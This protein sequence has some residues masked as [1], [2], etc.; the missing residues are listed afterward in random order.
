MLRHF[1]VYLTLSF[2]VMADAKA[3]ERK[4]HMQSLRRAA[5]KCEVELIPDSES[6]QRSERQRR[7]GKQ[8]LAHK[9]CP[10]QL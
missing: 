2:S 5:R 8:G 3:T 6:V 1:A 10:M 4:T 7:C 9:A